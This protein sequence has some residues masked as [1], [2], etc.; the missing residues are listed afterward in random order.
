MQGTVTFRTSLAHQGDYVRWKLPLIV[1]PSPASHTPTEHEGVRNVTNV[2][3]RNVMTRKN[4]VFRNWEV[5]SGR[6]LVCIVFLNGVCTLIIRV[7]CSEEKPGHSG[8][9]VHHALLGLTGNPSALIPGAEARR[10][11]RGGFPGPLACS[12]QVLG[13]ITHLGGPVWGV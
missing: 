12:S 4:S 6:G 8:E 11:A 9:G 13:L 5:I 10:R 2:G 1:V 7:F 3:V